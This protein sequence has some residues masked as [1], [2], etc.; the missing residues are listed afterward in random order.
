MDR[1]RAAFGR[2][3]EHHPH[4]AGD[5]VELA[6]LKW[7]L[8]NARAL[9]ALVGAGGAWWRGPGARHLPAGQLGDE[10]VG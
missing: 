6:I 3:E 4:V 5:G 7:E 8:G 9:R 1:S 10:L 2:G